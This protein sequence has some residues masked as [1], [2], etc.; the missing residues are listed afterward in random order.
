[1][2]NK[3]L[4]NF[5]TKSY[6]ADISNEKVAISQ[7]QTLK[8]VHGSVRA[9][10]IHSP[11]INL[12]QEEATKSLLNKKMADF[13]KAYDGGSPFLDYMDLSEL[14]LSPY[15]LAAAFLEGTDL[16]NTKLP[17]D[18][19]GIYL[20]N[21][22]LSGL[23][24]S[25]H[26]LKDATLY[27]A[28]LSGTKLP[29]D[30]TGVNLK[31]CD[32]SGRDLSQHIL[33]EA[34]LPDNIFSID[35]NLPADLTN[36]KITHA[37][38]SGL[39][40]SGYIL[41]GVDFSDSDLRNTK[42]P[43]D[44]TGA[45]F[46]RCNLLGLDLS[47]HIL[48]GADFYGIKNLNKIKLAPDLSGVGL[49]FTNLSGLDLSKTVL[50]GARLGSADLTNTV[51]PKDLTG[52]ALKFADFSGQD[53]S[54]H[55]LRGSDLQR[56][57]L[58]GAQLPK[59]LTECSLKSAKLQ[60]VDLSKHI[61]KNVNLEGVNFDDDTH[62]PP[63]E[64][65]EQGMLLNLLKLTVDV[66]LKHKELGKELID[67]AF[68]E[69]GEDFRDRISE[70]IVNK[71]KENPLDILETLYFL[72][73][74]HSQ[75]NYTLDLDLKKYKLDEF[76]K[77]LIKTIFAGGNKSIIFQ[78]YKAIQAC[79]EQEDLMLPF[80]EFLLKASTDEL[81]EFL[82]KVYKFNYYQ[83]FNQAKNESNID[84][85]NLRRSL[86]VSD[87]NQRHG[88]QQD[89]K[90]IV[91]D[92]IKVLGKKTLGQIIYS[93]RSKDE[94]E[95]LKELD[96][97]KSLEQYCSQNPDI[98][99]EV[100][101]HSDLRKQE[102]QKITA[103]ELR[104]EL[105]DKLG[106]ITTE[107]EN[108]FVQNLTKHYSI[109]DSKLNKFM[110][111]STNKDIKT[112]ANAFKYREEV[113][114]DNKERELI[115]TLIVNFIN[116]ENNN[117]IIKKA[118]SWIN[119]VKQSNPGFEPD[120]LRQEFISE[121]NG[122]T[123]KTLAEPLEFFSMS[124]A[125]ELEDYSCL[126]VGGTNANVVL[127][128]ALNAHTNVVSIE[129]NGEKLGRAL[130][131]IGDDGGISIFPIYRFSHSMKK[132]DMMPPLQEY[133]KEY[134]KFIGLNKDISNTK[135]LSPPKSIFGLETYYDDAVKRV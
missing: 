62:F 54:N 98:E 111:T 39:D 81:N 45:K 22:D 134:K 37:N 26:I 68:E 123:F 113:Y 121:H 115:D 114:V 120:K 84:Y 135:L 102:C 132:E 79:M 29:K 76:N 116:R 119:D 96:K 42:L 2:I 103:A 49:V 67:K 5:N 128:H 63:L 73:L 106:R 125:E 1:M 53:L 24:L 44:L 110:K 55:I 93:E 3:A 87:I 43:S 90:P 124:P 36:C 56:A 66:D 47:K 100:R 28:N 30:L 109:E 60:K 101:K 21:A 127:N 6:V 15:S 118:Q 85:S 8:E 133:L 31:G 11:V 41:R 92:Y 71:L 52:V 117:F 13:L 122:L 86:I 69:R 89:S 75:P 105:L 7:N 107:L 35:V 14:D 51:L 95:E 48:K 38:L 97:L 46:T 130:I 23:D 64:N 58:R 74:N 57:D 99:S 94:K 4:N 33:F 91:S 83:D 65:L 12:E 82:I 34:S 104:Q 72:R 9:N 88:I 27:G 17:K 16:R 126:S 25:Q 50:K 20:K 80:K 59:D 10:G 77:K 131:S 40:L 61:L 112:L 32:L 78:K 18:L 108:Q 129:Q 19:T 70:N